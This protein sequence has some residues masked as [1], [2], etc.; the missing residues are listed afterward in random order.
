M[1]RGV[2]ESVVLGGVVS[3]VTLSLRPS[4]MQRLLDA[5]LQVL[6]YELQVQYSA[7]QPAN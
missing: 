6:Q 1:K 2:V 5:W 3:P 7:Y 4:F